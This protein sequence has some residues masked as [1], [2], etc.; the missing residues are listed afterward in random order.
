MTRDSVF[1]Y[2]NKTVMVMEQHPQDD[3]SQG[4]SID[5]NKML[6]IKVNITPVEVADDADIS[7]PIAAAGK[8]SDLSPRP[9]SSS[10]TLKGNEQFPF[11]ADGSQ[12]ALQQDA[13]TPTTAC[14][15]DGS[16]LLGNSQQTRKLP[17][18]PGC[19]AQPRRYGPGTGQIS[20]T[21]PLSPSWISSDNE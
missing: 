7:R 18:T 1:H 21:Q 9:R 11:S 20:A 3:P 10:R 4:H 2:H 12:I 8:Q 17:C 13:P 6:S 15:Q 5:Q 14:P 16:V 19:K